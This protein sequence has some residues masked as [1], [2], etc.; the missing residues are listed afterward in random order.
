MKRKR[1]MSATVSSWKRPSS[2]AAVAAPSGTP[3]TPWNVSLRA[4][5]GACSHVS[6]LLCEA[7]HTAAAAAAAALPHH[8]VIRTPAS[9]SPGAPLAAGA[10]GRCSSAPPSPELAHRIA[11]LSALGGDTARPGD[12]VMASRMRSAG[13]GKQG[14]DR[15]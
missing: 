14:E 11:I 5:R 7:S 15:R 6:L 8:Q 2:T 12:I 4:R 3:A 13:V 10:G 1:R 9:S